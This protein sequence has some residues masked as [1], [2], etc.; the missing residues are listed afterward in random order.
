MIDGVQSI[1][2][3]KYPHNAL[4]FHHTNHKLNLA[5][6]DLNCVAENCNTILTVKDIII[7]F[8]CESVLRRK[9]IPSTL[10]F[11]ETQSSKNIEVRCRT[12]V[13]FSFCQKCTNQQSWISFWRN[14]FSVSNFCRH[15]LRT[16]LTNVLIRFN[17][18]H[19]L[20]IFPWCAILWWTTP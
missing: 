19:W 13:Y 15:F 3:V 6:S 9:F 7:N 5:V 17:R 2:L 20:T 11:Y 1:L 10:A 4:F 16:F 14:L 12:S 18:K 8:F